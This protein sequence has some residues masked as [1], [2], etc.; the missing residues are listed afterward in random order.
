MTFVRIP[1]S[2]WQHHGDWLLSMV[3]QELSSRMHAPT[4]GVTSVPAD[5]GSLVADIGAFAQVMPAEW[6]KEWREAEPWTRAD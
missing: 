4:E 3:Q 1:S 5:L 2:V 6:V